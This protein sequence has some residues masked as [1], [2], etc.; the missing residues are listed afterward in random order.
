MMEINSRDDLKK[1]LIS[2]E[3]EIHIN[4][5]KLTIGIITRPHKHRSFLTCMKL[6]GYRLITAKCFGV[7]DV[8]F[9]KA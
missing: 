8:K 7:F 5:K 6:K 4:D 1:A 2:S 9:V 3:E